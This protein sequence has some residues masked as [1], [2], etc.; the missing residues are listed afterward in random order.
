MTIRVKIKQFLFITFFCAAWAVPSAARGQSFQEAGRYYKENNYDR[1]IEAYDKIR[2]DGFES[3]EL[4]Y[5]LGNSYFKKG[6][7]GRALLNFE[8]AKFFIPHDGD[9][10]SNYD[11]VRSALNSP[12]RYSYEPWFFRWVDRLFDSI[13]MNILTIIVSALWISILVLLSAAMF[14]PAFRRFLFLSAGMLSVF[15]VICSLSLARKAAFYERGAVIVGGEI[16]AK[17]EPASGATTYFKLPEGSP[18]YALDRSAGWVKIRR[19]DA[20]IGW[21][22]SSSVAGIR[23]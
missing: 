5:N 8:R 21:V 14:A 1:A 4:Y 9:L 3:G 12:V 2:R 13:A 23:E 19:P 20:K 6:D 17:F 16:E 15:L 10:R 18:V 7:L 22:P 11:Y